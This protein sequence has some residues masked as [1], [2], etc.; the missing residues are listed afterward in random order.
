MKKFKDKQKL[1]VGIWNKDNIDTDIII[2]SDYLKVVKKEG[3]GE[4]L[5][6]SVRFIDNGK[7]GILSNERKKNKNFFLNKKSYRKS[8]VLIVGKNFGCGS[9]REHA[10][11]AIIDYGIKVIISPS[12]ANIFYENS[13]KNGLLLIELKSVD[14]KYLMKYFTEEIALKEKIFIDLKNQ[15][16]ITKDKEFLFDINEDKKKSLLRGLDEVGIILEKFSKDI[17]KFENEHKNKYP[18]LYK[19]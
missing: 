12:F 13:F 17:K 8:E 4:Y 14:V 18:F 5:F 16:V 10:P 19:K 6:D 11:W 1:L 7:L 15:K 9:S 2:P 3:L